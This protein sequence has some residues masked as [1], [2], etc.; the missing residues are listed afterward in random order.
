M[1]SVEVVIG[2]DSIR[3]DVNE[4][5]QSA[6]VCVSARTQPG[7]KMEKDYPVA[8]RTNQNNGMWVFI[9]AIL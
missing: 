8:I 3:Y 9:K 6:S 1:S 7:V 4:N 2:F 5:A